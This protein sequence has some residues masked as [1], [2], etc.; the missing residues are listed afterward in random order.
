MSDDQGEPYCSNCGRAWRHC[1]SCDDQ[2]TTAP[3]RVCESCKAG[4]LGD[5]VAVP[6]AANESVK[7]EFARSCKCGV[8]RQTARLT[9]RALHAI[10]ASCPKEEDRWRQ[11]YFLLGCE[12]DDA[13]E[14][15]LRRGVP[16]SE[17]VVVGDLLTDVEALKS[18]TW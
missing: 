8:T 11:T 10:I 5:W 18:G 16:R 9:S 1:A 6:R 13:N 14:D 3:G 4:A 7:F 12:I 2:D 17:L 15:A